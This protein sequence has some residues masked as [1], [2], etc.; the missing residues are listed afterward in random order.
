VS[1]GSEAPPAGGHF[2][3]VEFRRQIAA[4]IDCV[5]PIRGGKVRLIGLELYGDGLIL[6]WLFVREVNGS[7]PHVGISL[8]SEIHGCVIEDDIGTSFYPSSYAGGRSDLVE[9]AEVSFVP[10][11]PATA[12][13]LTA[14][15]A[16]Q[17]FVIATK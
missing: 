4:P 14:S 10:A 15:L 11:L 2:T 1:D 5:R 16:G 17:D 9:R 7:D 3:G 8:L 6:R 12:S 13:I